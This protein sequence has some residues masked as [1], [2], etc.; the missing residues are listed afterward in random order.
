MPSRSRR[1]SARS[2]SRES[3][4]RSSSMGVSFASVYAT[5]GERFR[6]NCWYIRLKQRGAPMKLPALAAM[7]VLTAGFGA[8]AFAQ[9]GM[10]VLK[11]RR[12]QAEM[13]GTL[14]VD[15]DGI[16]GTEIDFQDTFGIEDKEDF[17]ELHLT[18]GF[19]GKMN[20]Q[21]LTGKFE[22]SD[23]VTQDVRFG[24][25]VFTVGTE[26]DTKVEFDLYTALWQIGVT[27]PVFPGVS[28]GLGGQ[29]GIK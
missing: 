10:L 28:V 27:L 14:Q 22:G 2:W 21:Y 11:A 16:A 20:L 24:D 19:L 25:V 17:N 5:A 23:T 4:F 6:R 13:D 1:I 7:L 26:V 9:D 3:A 15:D 29:V 18:I 8:E 12:W